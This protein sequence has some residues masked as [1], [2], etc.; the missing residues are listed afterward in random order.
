MLSCDA[1]RGDDDPAPHESIHALDL[2]VRRRLRT[3]AGPRDLDADV[4]AIVRRHVEMAGLDVLLTVPRNADNDARWAEAAPRL[5]GS[6]PG[7][8]RA[9]IWDR[10]GRV[11]W[12]EDATA[13]DRA[14][15]KPSL[16]R[17]LTGTIVAQLKE[18]APTERAEEFAALMDV[19]VPILTSEGRVTGVVEV[20]KEPTLLLTSLRW[21][22][23]GIWAQCEDST[24]A[25]RRSTTLAGAG[26]ARPATRLPAG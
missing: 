3:D 7:L 24:S 9:R 1:K 21:G 20:Y 19:D 14:P 13:I 2:R 11:V 17:A 15:A 8:T 5:V 10:E 22:L 26:R 4:A 25:E 23:A 18:L 16:R 12:S 6:L